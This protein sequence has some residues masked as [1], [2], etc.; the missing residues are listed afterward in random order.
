MPIVG[1]NF[2]KIGCERGEARAEKVNISNNISLKDVKETELSLGNEKQKVIKFIFE[3]VSKYEP[4][5]GKIML[6]GEV[7][8]LEGTPKAQKIIEDWKKTKNLEK[9][10]MTFLLDTVLSKCNVQALI[11]SQEV[12]LPS[13]IPLPK[14]KTDTKK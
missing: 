3:F 11:L 7:L 1:F 9:D 12:N 14:I 6:V 13:P 10:L 2:T 5:I 8:Y 4:S